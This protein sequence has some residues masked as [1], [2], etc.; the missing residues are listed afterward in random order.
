MKRLFFSMREI[1]PEDLDEE[2]MEDF[3]GAMD[4]ISNVL[5]RIEKKRQKHQPTSVPMKI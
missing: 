5:Y 2:T 3:G 1:Q 4:Q